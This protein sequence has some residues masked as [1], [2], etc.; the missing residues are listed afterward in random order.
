MNEWFSL[1][2]IATALTIGAISPGPSFVVVART[3]V[4]AGRAQ[5][6]ATAFGIAVAGAILATIAL[7]G[8]HSVLL[9][10]P[11][12]F[13]V[14][15][16]LGGGYLVYLGLRIIFAAKHALVMEAM[17]TDAEHSP[18]G[19]SKGIL[20]RYFRNGFTTQIINPKTAIVFASV[21][22]AF[23]P[24]HTS[25]AF[26]LATVCIVFSIE[27]LWYSIVS[28]LLSTSAP[29]AVYLRHKKWLDRAAGSVMGAL[30]VKLLSSAAQ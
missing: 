21:F 12:L 27:L 13:M 2:G 18:S 17:T 11:K 3:A 28:L 6:V 20:R 8:L 22:T 25:W 9:A 14:L 16:V 30:G 29:R 19:R 4:S 10:V 23:L 26:N 7:M 24:A 15:K 1:L 5:G